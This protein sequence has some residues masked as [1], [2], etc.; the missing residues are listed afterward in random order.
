MNKKCLICKGQFSPDKWHTYQE[1]CFKDECKREWR[2]R[3]YQNWLKRNPGY[4][5][6]GGRDNKE[7]NKK[8]R[9]RN[10]GYYKKYR[11]RHPELRKKNVE[12]VRRY[13]EKQDVSKEQIL[14]QNI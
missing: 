2:K 9:K 10:L 11:R 5:K 3:C 8:W 6:G 4:F 1:V 7:A 12:Y 14:A 13:R